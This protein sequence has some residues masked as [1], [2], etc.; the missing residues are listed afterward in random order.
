M[1][2][3]VRRDDPLIARGTDGANGS[4]ECGPNEKLRDTHPLQFAKVGFANSSAQPI[5]HTRSAGSAT[6]ELLQ[7]F[8]V[9]GPLHRD[10]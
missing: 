3:C 10:P 7:M 6:D 1:G 8:R 9:P 5:A 2:P 4:R